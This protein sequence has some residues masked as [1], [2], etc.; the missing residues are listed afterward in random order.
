M[1]TIDSSV[2]GYSVSL[3][4]ICYGNID[5]SVSGHSVSLTEIYYGY[6]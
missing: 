2:S 3:T 4:E 1:G 6:H 5:S